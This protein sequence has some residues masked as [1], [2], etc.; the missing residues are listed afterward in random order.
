MRTTSSKQSIQNV[1]GRRWLYSEGVVTGEVFIFYL[2]IF[3]NWNTI[4]PCTYV[5][6]TWKLK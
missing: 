5:L 2:F 1:D 4:D 3:N 6:I